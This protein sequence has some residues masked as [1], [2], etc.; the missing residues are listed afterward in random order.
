MQVAWLLL[1]VVLGV[2]LT[3]LIAPLALVALPGPAH[4]TTLLVL[5]GIACIAIVSFFRRVVVGTPRAGVKR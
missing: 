2:I 1:D 5:V 3:G 4:G